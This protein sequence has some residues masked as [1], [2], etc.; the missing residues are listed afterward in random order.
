MADAGASSPEWATGDAK[1]DLSELIITRSGDLEISQSEISQR[2]ADP[3]CAKRGGRFLSGATVSQHW[4]NKP[5][6]KELP[7]PATA[8][9]FAYALECS[10]AEIYIAALHTIGILQVDGPDA[11]RIFIAHAN[12]WASDQW[13]QIVHAMRTSAQQT[14]EELT[15]MEQSGGN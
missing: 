1:L 8:R 3:E 14:S 9:A 11:S 2:T 7:K 10:V 15:R 4:N 6:M 13:R 5:P 12:G